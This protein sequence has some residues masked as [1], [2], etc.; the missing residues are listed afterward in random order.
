MKKTKIIA[1][2]GPAA[3]DYGRL[4]ELISSGVNVFRLNF[5]HGEYDFF[6]RTINDIKKARQA[7]G[8]A[9]SIL[10]DLQG[11]KIR[12][13]SMKESVN[14][15]RGDVLVIREVK[16]LGPDG[17]AASPL[18]KGK[19]GAEGSL[20]SISIDFKELY[21]YVL[22][23]DRILINDGMVQLKVNK[24]KGMDIVCAVINGGEI[25]ER[26]GVN[27]PGVK[28]PLS[29]MTKK[30]VENLRFGL[31]NNIDIV[32]LSF[33]R[34]AQ[35]IICLKKIIASQKKCRP[36]VIAKIEKPEAVKNIEAILKES[37]GI[38]VARGDLA[39]EAGFKRIPGMQKELIKK[40][41]AT[42]KIVIVATQMLESMTNNPYPERAE[43]T[44]V[45]NAV[46]DGADAL[47]LSGETSIGKYPVKTARTMADIIRKAESESTADEFSTAGKYIKTGS[48][49]ENVISYAGTA[50]QKMLPDAE[51]AVRVDSIDDVQFISDYR[52]KKPVIAAVSDEE[53]YNKMAIFHGIYPV[54]MKDMTEIKIAGMVKK[55]L[56]NTGNIIYID[57]D[58]QKNS[59]GR[60]SIIKV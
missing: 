35:D 22:P 24:I 25:A 6:K 48:I 52:P 14:V 32:C 39:V 31:K 59:G 43:I 38:M 57:F 55:H 26:K 23:G 2:L 54:Y 60:L 56:K 34:T 33:V 12:V 20:K 4:R 49:Y 37:D 17:P 7:E 19:S 40:A 30:D 21:K 9:V 53:L 15:K 8:Q 50:A 13:M 41:N 29:S 36:L 18:I 27:L 45:Y 47:M 51:I 5:S 42:G 28:L 11:P 44:D 16:S 46:L 58:G 10:Q 1:T 3:K